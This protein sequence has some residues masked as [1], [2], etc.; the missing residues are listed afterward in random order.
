MFTILSEA[1][2][3]YTSLS[4]EELL[5]E[6]GDVRDVRLVF[7]LKATFTYHLWSNG[8][9]KGVLVPAPTGGKRGK[10]LFSFASIRKFL[11]E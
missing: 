9:I 8:K 10:R 2:R 4:E 5:R 1:P 3:R 7:G 11:A 6:Y